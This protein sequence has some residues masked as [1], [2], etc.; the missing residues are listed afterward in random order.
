M[1]GVV[2]LPR[3]AAL[4]G[5]G[6]S[7]RREQSEESR[8]FTTS[9]VVVHFNTFFQR[10]ESEMAGD[11]GSRRAGGEKGI[12]THPMLSRVKTTWLAHFGEPVGKAVE[13]RFDL[14]AG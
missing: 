7:D 2:T 5:V 13:F 1:T 9:K 14:F 8:I 11:G 10:A 3:E 12:N 6:I 4:G